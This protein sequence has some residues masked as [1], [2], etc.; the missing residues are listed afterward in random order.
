MRAP[1]PADRPP[2]IWRLLANRR[3]FGLFI[4]G[5][6]LSNIGTWC[7]NVAAIIVVYRLTGDVAMVALVTVAQYVF[8]VFLGPYAGVLA[9]RFDRRVILG[10]TQLGG[11]LASAGLAY[12]ALNEAAPLVWLFVL[13]GFLG[14]FQAFQS[15]A[16]LSITPSLVARNERDLGLSLTAMQFNLARVIGPIVASS[17]IVAFGAASAFAVNA[18]SYLLFFLVLFAIKPRRRR[19]PATR[20]TL[21]EGLVVLRGAPVIVLLL[22]VGVVTFGAT[23]VVTTLGPAISTRLTNTDEW[24][25]AFIAA[26]GIGAVLMAFFGVPLLRRSR[27]QLVPMLTVVSVCV[28]AFVWAPTVPIAV[29]ACSIFGAAFLAVGNRALVLLQEAVHQDLIGRIAALWVVAT[30]AGRVLIAGVE[31]AV[32]AI[33]SA[34]VAGIVVAVLVAGVAVAV[35]LVRRRGHRLPGS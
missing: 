35:I 14:V 12:V 16:M 26:F 19:L 29:L 3:R 34:E 25:G 9:D 2:S 18:V 20:P 22:T 7:Q 4:A 17:L 23:D 13:I 11:V 15:P 21:R 32:T 24:V 30:T 31:A 5:S 28:V 1:G 27:A 8:T 6:A 10:V 33:S